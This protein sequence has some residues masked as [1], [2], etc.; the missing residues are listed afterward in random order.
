MIHRLTLHSSSCQSLQSLVILWSPKRVV[1]SD[2]VKRH[3]IIPQ[4]I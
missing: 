4:M 2:F 3:G 1:T